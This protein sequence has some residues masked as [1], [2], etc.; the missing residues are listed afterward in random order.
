MPQADKS[1]APTG[2]LQ[3]W[4]DADGNLDQS[5]DTTELTAL[6][7]RLDPGLLRWTKALL[8]KLD[9]N[10]DGKLSAHELQQLKPSPADGESAQQTG[11]KPAQAPQR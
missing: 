8:D 6:L 11:S 1:N 3:P 5:I 4:L 2:L 10:K 9:S 7:R